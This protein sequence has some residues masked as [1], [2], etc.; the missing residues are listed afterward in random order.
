MKFTL[1]NKINNP[2]V[3]K[4]QYKFHIK[5]MHGDATQYEENSWLCD[6]ELEAMMD[7]E[8]YK[9]AL[10]LCYEGK[11]VNDISAEVLKPVLQR[12]K[13]AGCCFLQN[14]DVDVMAESYFDEVPSDCTGG[15]GQYKAAVD[16]IWVTY[17]DENGDEFEVTV[18]E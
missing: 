1:G 15:D 7:Y 11:D 5:F 8:T 13:N 9:M 14:E 6:D 16:T 3:P 10:N 17:F 2:P 18:D 4:S 12:Y